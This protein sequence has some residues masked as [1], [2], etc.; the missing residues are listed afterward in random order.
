MV[1]KHR[2]HLADLR[3]QGGPRQQRQN[4]AAQ[5]LTGRRGKTAPGRGGLRVAHLPQAQRKHQRQGVAARGEQGGKA[6]REKPFGGNAGGPD[7]GD[8]QKREQERQRHFPETPKPAFQEEHRSGKR[9]KVEK[10]SS[11]FFQRLQKQL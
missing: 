7:P 9:R 3:Q 4:A 8:L 1:Q 6:K 2:G 5:R 10:V 11:E